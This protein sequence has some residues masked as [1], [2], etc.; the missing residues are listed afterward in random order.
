[1]AGYKSIRGTCALCKQ[2]GVTNYHYKKIH[3]LIPKEIFR[4]V[5]ATKAWGCHLHNVQSPD[6]HTM[7]WHYKQVH[8]GGPITGA[9]LDVDTLG[10]KLPEQ[11]ITEEAIVTAFEERVKGIDELLAEKDKELHLL[12]TVISELNAQ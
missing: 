10:G 7:M 8:M 2:Q 12:H 9:V 1:M 4:Y 6:P 11:T 3:Q 5:N